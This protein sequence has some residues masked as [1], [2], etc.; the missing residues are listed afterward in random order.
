MSYRYKIIDT[1]MIPSL[2]ASR[3]LLFHIGFSGTHRW[4]P[5]GKLLEFDTIFALQSSFPKE[6]L[7]YSACKDMED[8]IQ[9]LVRQKICEVLVHCGI[10]DSS[11]GGDGWGGGW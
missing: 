10:S 1:V 2:L 4:P 8:V 5:F 7:D 11:D 3:F 9:D 6:T